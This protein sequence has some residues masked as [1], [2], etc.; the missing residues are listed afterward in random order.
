MGERINAHRV[1]TGKPDGYIPLKR[2]RNIWE[3]NVK[4]Y[5]ELWWRHGLD[6]SGSGEGKITAFVTVVMNYQVA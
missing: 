1:L 3:G 4:I 2:P 5:F 6:W